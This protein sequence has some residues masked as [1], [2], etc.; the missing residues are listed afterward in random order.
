MSETLR[1][2]SSSCLS[3]YFDR[4]AL[5]SYD[6]IGVAERSA[7]GRMDSPAKR[8]RPRSN[9]EREDNPASPRSSRAKLTRPPTPGTPPSPLVAAVDSLPLE[10]DYTANATA[11]QAHIQ[12][13]RLL[14]TPLP[15]AHAF[16]RL[17]SQHS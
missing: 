2:E 7:R 13:E 11:K 3:R 15:Q 1:E 6:R 10:S 5:R 12:M 16:A 9:L 17:S 8:E 14:A 4:L